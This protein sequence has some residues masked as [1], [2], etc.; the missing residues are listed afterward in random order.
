MSFSAV[1]NDNLIKSAPH[2][3]PHTCIYTQAQNK[4]QQLK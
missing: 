2:V 4:G 3:H 1:K